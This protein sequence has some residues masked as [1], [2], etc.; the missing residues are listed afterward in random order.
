M[1]VFKHGMNGTVSDLTLTQEMKKLS[2]RE[3]NAYFVY[4]DLSPMLDTQN[5]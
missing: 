2:K 3:N 4:G 5:N 1:S